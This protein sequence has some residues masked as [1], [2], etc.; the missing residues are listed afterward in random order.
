MVVSVLTSLAQFPLLARTI[1]LGRGVLSVFQYSSTGSH[2]SGFV[3]EKRSS[4]SGSFGFRFLGKR[5][6]RLV[7]YVFFWNSFFFCCEDFLCFSVFP[8]FSSDLGFG[9][10]TNFLVFFLPFSK[11]NRESK[12]RVVSDPSLV[13]APS[14]VKPFLGNY[15]PIHKN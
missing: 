15:C 6:R 2:G 1:L 8:V 5:L 4:G 10:D 7:L 9:R 12:D 14:C 3:A 11:K 13:P